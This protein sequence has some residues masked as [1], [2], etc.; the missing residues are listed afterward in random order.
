MTKPTVAISRGTCIP[1]ARKGIQALASNTTAT[2]VTWKNS[3][4]KLQVRSYVS[5]AAVVV[6]FLFVLYACASSVA[7]ACLTAASL[8]ASLLHNPPRAHLRVLRVAAGVYTLTLCAGM[9]APRAALRAVFE[10]ALPT[11]SESTSRLDD[12]SLSLGNLARTLDM[13]ALAHILGFAVKG[14]MVG[15]RRT[16][17]IAG[18]VFESLEWA[19]GA[20]APIT[21]PTLS[22]CVFDRIFLDL[23]LC[24][25]LGIELGL[26]I[27]RRFRSDRKVEPSF[28]CLLSMLFPGCACAV[29]DILHF[30]MIAALRIPI[31]AP[32]L[33][34]RIALLASLGFPA[35]SEFREYGASGVSS[36]QFVH[37]QAMALVFFGEAAFCARLLM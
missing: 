8:W 16:L 26:A 30:C 23:L 20:F 14:A 31:D 28:P 29:A 21:F 4:Q 33:S 19:L 37:V 10:H 24:N 11:A 15:D 7:A 27:R 12:C 1:S 13:Y 32:I 5:P 34:A 6:A 36:T 3:A 2:S 9:A 17:W 25:A 18:V 22:E 35:M